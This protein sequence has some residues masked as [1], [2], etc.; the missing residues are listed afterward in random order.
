MT[1]KPPS[2]VQEAPADAAEKIAY[3]SVKEIPT[4]ETNDRHRLGYHIWRWMGHR[5]GTIEQ[6]VLESG[7]RILIPAK[8][9]ARV[10]AEELK[11]SG[12]QID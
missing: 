6:A 2:A 7:S 5:H 12:I 11:K 4:E 9:A 8:D 3:N 10:I 1:T